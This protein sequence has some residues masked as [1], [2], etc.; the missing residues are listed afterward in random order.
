MRKSSEKSAIAYL[1]SVDDPIGAI[2]Q[3]TDVNIKVISVSQ[4]A[5]EKL[6]QSE[7]LIINLDDAEDSEDRKEMQKRHGIVIL[8][9]DFLTC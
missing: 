5:N 7:I 9:Y 4:L 3:L 6:P 2:Y 8:L 1:P